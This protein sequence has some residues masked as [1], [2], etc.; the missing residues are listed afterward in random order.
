MEIVIDNLLPTF[1]EKSAVLNSEVWNKKVSFS[2]GGYTQIVSP[3]GSGKT[4]L[5]NFLYGLKKDYSGGISFN[6]KLLSDINIEEL[7]RLRQTKISIVF[8]DLK[9]FD[10]LTCFENLII[11]QS[12][13]NHISKD[14]IQEYANR[15]KIGSKLSNKINICS[16]GERQRVA[17]IRSLLQ[18]FE[19]L[20]LDEPFSH[21]DNRNVDI[22]MDLIN[23]RSKEQNATLILA[24]LESNSFF[25]NHSTLYL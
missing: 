13:S 10:D 25:N 22:A 1:L 21:L 9:L 5:I 12:L 18:P 8:Q 11:K 23:E 17:I 14:L 7:S 24:D 3:S 2:E 4:S 16:Y 19:V 15:L 20:L 6:G